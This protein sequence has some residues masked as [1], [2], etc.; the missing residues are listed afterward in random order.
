MEWSTE[1]CSQTILNAK[2][3]IYINNDELTNVI[4]ENDYGNN[5][6][7]FPDRDVDSSENDIF[8]ST[9][10]KV[11]EQQSFSKQADAELYLKKKRKQ[12]ADKLSQAYY[13][14]ESKSYMKALDC[15]EEAI[16]MIENDCYP[17]EYQLMP[18]DIYAIKYCIALCNLR[19][20]EYGSLQSAVSQLKHLIE[21]KNFG[22]KWP[23]LYLSLAEVHL[24]LK[25]HELCTNVLKSGLCVLSNFNSAVSPN[26]PGTNNNVIIELD[27][28]QLQHKMNELLKEATLPNV[29]DA[30][31]CYSSCHLVGNSQKAIYFE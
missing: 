2:N 12:L 6:I 24:A 17:D 26:W 22:N 8:L 11:H 15:F 13:F 25:H 1:T 29:P 5:R 3:K 19:R 9:L 31:C 21:D 27:S 30:Y 14:Y 16:R 18:D 23:V 7:M 28:S 4:I 20:M 10:K